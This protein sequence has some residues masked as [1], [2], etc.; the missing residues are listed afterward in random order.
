MDRI[1]KRYRG[2]GFRF[3][4]QRLA[5]LKYLEGNTSH[6]AA[7]DIYMAI[8]REYPTVSFATVYN[9]VEMLK[10][11]G[12][13]QEITIDPER[14][15]YDP[16]PNPHHHII[17]TECNKIVDVFVDYSDVLNLPAGL[18]REFAVAGNHVDFYGVCRDCRNQ[19]E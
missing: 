18:K 13:V 3:T 19:P 1:F 4:P 6:P 10:E 12:E 2:K 16:N 5:I 9:T 7:D 14:K 11:V 8:K 17:C 15:H